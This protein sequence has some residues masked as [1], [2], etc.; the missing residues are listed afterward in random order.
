MPETP[1]PEGAAGE[2]ALKLK[3]ASWKT[4]GSAE[5][6]TRCRPRIPTL[7]DVVLQLSLVS[8]LIP[9]SQWYYRLTGEEALPLRERVISVT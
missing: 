8:G 5:P 7:M 2:G 4:Q 1:P 3:P 9:P 6:R